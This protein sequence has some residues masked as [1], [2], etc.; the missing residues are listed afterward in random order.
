MGTSKRRLS[1]FLA[2]L[3]GFA[4]AEQAAAQSSPEDFFR[5][6]TLRV[7][8]P[9]SPGAAR[10]TSATLFTSHFRKHIPGNPTVVPSFMP[11]AGGAVG[12]NYLYN[13]APRDG[14][15]IIT[16]LTTAVLAQAIGEKSTKYDVTK[17]HWIGR[18]AIN[19]QIVYVW[20]TTGV[21]DIEG[22]RQKQITLGSSGAGSSQ[23]ILPLIMN[24]TL[25]T[26]FK[27][28]QGYKGSAAFNLAV[29]R[30]EL[31]AALTTWAT[32]RAASH[33][34][35]VE[36]GKARVIVQLAL[37]R[38]PE[39]SNVPLASDLT[40][41]AD[42]KALLEFAS[43]TAEFGQAFV[44]PPDVPAPIIAALRRAFDETIKDPEYIAAATKADIEIS[45][46]TGDQMAELAQRM[47]SVPQRIIERYK[48][49]VGAN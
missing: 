37:T 5:G 42:A 19:S 4:L 3:A 11:G 1:A 33:L 27:V 36:S 44:A 29:E 20:H 6:K 38:H 10:G 23:T 43:S 2:I 49:A 12:M 18:N 8:I 32:L 40:T 24:E 16:P 48:A 41:D 15:V 39:L 30:G 28:I 34:E 17:M 35:W 14:T 45:P 22:V 7:V 47:L 31:D 46:M 21:T 9:A 26:K 25:G 13:V